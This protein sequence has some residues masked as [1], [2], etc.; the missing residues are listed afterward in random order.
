MS[1]AAPVIA[2]DGPSGSGKGTIAAL[3]AEKLGFW[4]LDSGAIYRVIALAANRAGIDGAQIPDLVDLA[5]RVSIEFRAA[6]P[7]QV[8]RVLLDGADVSDQVRTEQV[9]ALASRIA[10]I[11]AVREALL[12]RQRAFCRPPGLVADGRDMASVV[13]P[14]A[15][16]KL[17]LTAD[18][19][20]RAERRHKQLI[21]KGIDVS[22]AALVK[23]ISERDRRDS[24]RTVA[25]LKPVPDAVVIDTSGLTIEMVLERCLHVVSR[26]LT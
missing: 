2:I 16:A 10:V 14:N 19:R 5:R 15:A 1:S 6:G 12:E 9:G 4:L 18:P 8:T 7:G 25:P 23:D 11:P 24:S 13:F 20:E 3:L 21:E 17:F 22:L 26:S